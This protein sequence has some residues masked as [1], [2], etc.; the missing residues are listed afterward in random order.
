MAPRQLIESLQY[1]PVYMG[2]K[3]DDPLSCSMDSVSVVR[4]FETEGGVI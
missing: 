1:W 3:Q 4:V 2:M